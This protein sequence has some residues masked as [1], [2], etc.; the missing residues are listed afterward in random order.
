MSSAARIARGV[1]GLIVL[2]VLLLVV[3]NWYGDFKGAPRQTES[4]STVES[5]TTTSSGGKGSTPAPAANGSVIETRV[6][7]IDGLKFREKADLTSTSIRG[8]EKGESLAV[9]G[10]EGDWY[11]VRTSDGKVGYVSANLQYTKKAK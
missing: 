9:L 11:K 6:V 1:V 3:W 2:V 10:K 8:L 5:S 4:T 7:L